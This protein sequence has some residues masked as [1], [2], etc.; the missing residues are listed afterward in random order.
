M[1]N[2]IN[3][4]GFVFSTDPDFKPAEEEKN[5]SMVPPQKQVLRIWLERE[6]VNR[7]QRL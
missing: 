5:T 3:L 7:H 1:S 4:G 6:G 2:K